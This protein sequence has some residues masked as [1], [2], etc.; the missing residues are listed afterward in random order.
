MKIKALAAFAACVVA[1]A[2]QTANSGKMQWVQFQP[3]EVF[4]V[5]DARCRMLAQTQQQGLYAQ[6]TPGFV[7]GAQMGNAIGNAIRMEQFYKQCMTISGWK[8]IPVAKPV[9]KAG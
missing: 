6:G 7:I 1:S 5:A 2:C 8:Q 3:G 4:E 9:K